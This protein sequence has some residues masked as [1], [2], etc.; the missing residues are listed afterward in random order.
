MLKLPISSK[1]K[2]SAPLNLTEASLAAVEAVDNGAFITKT[3]DL[4]REMAKDA[5]A[6]L[7]KGE[8]GLI[9]GVP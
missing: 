2:K 5:D 6:A 3:P 8:G 9:A 4:A 7:A 1:Q